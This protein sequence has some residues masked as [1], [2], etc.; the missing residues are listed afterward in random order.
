MTTPAALIASWLVLGCAALGAQAG[1]HFSPAL[2]GQPDRAFLHRVGHEPMAPDPTLRRY[3]GKV[4]AL[5]PAD[6]QG[7]VYGF[8]CAPVGPRNFPLKTDDLRGWRM[9]VLSGKRFGTVFRI[10]GNSG[11]EIRVNAE[12]GPV[13][14]LAANDVFVIESIDAN[15]ASMFATP[16]AAPPP[17]SGTG[18]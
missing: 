16:P 8:T 3:T 18:A 5:A 12:T 2:P 14:G 1:A 4:T 10:A 17:A 9:T 6:A 13:Q 7:K 11:T 15:G